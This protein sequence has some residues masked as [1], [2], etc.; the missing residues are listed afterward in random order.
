MLKSGKAPGMDGLVSKFLIETAD[1]TCKP[2][3]LIY[4][5]FSTMPKDWKTANVM[6]IFKNGPRHCPG[7]YR[8]ASLISYL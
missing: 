1:V 3:A 4:Q 5:K 2:L 7:N 6:T 8:P